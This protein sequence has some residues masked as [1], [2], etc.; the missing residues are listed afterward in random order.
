MI[1]EAPWVEARGN[2]AAPG[3]VMDQ[4]RI[5]FSTIEGLA[6]EDLP[7]AAEIWLYDVF[8]APWASREA[9]KLAAHFVRYM[10]NPDPT[11]VIVRE[12]ER[13]YQLVR[14]DLQRALLLMRNFMAID[15]YTID[16]DDIKVAL[17]LSLLQRLKVLETRRL[18]AELTQPENAAV[19]Q[20]L[21]VR[22]PRWIPTDGV[23][24][25]E[26]EEAAVAPLVALISEHIRH[27]AGRDSATTAA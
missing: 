25:P 16:K 9:M 10:A 17:N 23:S 18:L 2:L 7:L 3:A 15:G 5:R 26:L 27:A 20:P 24:A 22:E 14:D 11:R 13:E 12:I 4:R 6:R 8:H 19:P 21:P 1:R